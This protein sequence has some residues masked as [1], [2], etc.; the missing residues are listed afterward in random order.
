MHSHS[1]P[2]YIVLNYGSTFKGSYDNVKQ[3]GKVLTPVLKRNGMY[4]WKIVLPGGKTEIC[5]GFWINIDGAL[6]ASFMP[7]IRMA[8]KNG[9]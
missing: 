3:I 1:D 9:L 6:G 7:F 5:K 8:A 2:V 4:E